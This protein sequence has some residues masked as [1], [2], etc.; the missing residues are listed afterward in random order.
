MTLDSRNETERTMDETI[1]L[2]DDKGRAFEV[3]IKKILMSLGV[4][5]GDLS[6]ECDDFKCSVVVTKKSS[7][8]EPAPPS[9]RVT[10]KETSK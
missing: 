4:R 3:P 2:V 6:V 9:S 1:T 8:T 10:K 5:G 7:V